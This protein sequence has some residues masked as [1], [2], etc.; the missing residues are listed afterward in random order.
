MQQTAELSRYLAPFLPAKMQFLASAHTGRDALHQPYMSAPGAGT[1]SGD[2]TISRYLLRSAASPLYPSDP[3]Q[4]AQVDLW[5]DLY[6]AV[7]GGGSSDDVLALANRH[8]MDKNFVVGYGLTAADVA[9]YLVAKKDKTP[10][11]LFTA[12]AR[13]AVF[14]APMLKPPTG[15]TKPKA[16]APNSKTDAAKDKGKGDAG[17]GDA[18]TGTGKTGGGASAGGASAGAKTDK[19]GAAK[20][21]EEEDE[22]GSCPPLEGAEDGKVCTRFPPEP[23]GYLHIGHAKAVLL[24]Q[25]YAQVCHYSLSVIAMVFAA[26]LEYGFGLTLMKLDMQGK[27][28]AGPTC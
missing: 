6:S 24:N 15:I 19:D 3:W 18:S 8:L 20:A 26:E 23:S 12:V 21:D 11:P 17:K 28:P 2:A 16:E 5:L 27:N 22:G 10:N 1:I 9:L 13:W 4:A 14:V 7:I 25:Y